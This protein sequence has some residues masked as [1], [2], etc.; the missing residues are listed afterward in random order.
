MSLP[1]WIVTPVR[2]PSSADS[3]DQSPLRALALCFP[4]LTMQELDAVWHQLRTPLFTLGTTPISVAGIVGF[5]LIVFGAWWLAGTIEKSIRRV[6]ASRPTSAAS[7]YAWAR[8][9][10]YG[11]WV[12]ATLV[13][14][15]YIG[16]DIANF[17]LLGGAVGV[18]IGF[19]LQNIF[20]NF[21]SGIILLVEKTLKEGDFVDLQSGT[22]GHVREIGLR[23]TRI[24]TNDEVDVIVPNSE[25]I[26]GRV[27]NW[28]FGSRYR[29]MHVPFGV[30][31][32]SDK[33]QVKAAALRAAQALPTTVSDDTRHSDVWLVAM[34]ESSLDFELVV[35]VGADATTSPARVEAGYIWQLHEELL[36]AGLEI[37]YPQRD[38]HIRSGGLTVRLDSASAA[39][40]P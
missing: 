4:S 22:R 24:T 11:I 12:L 7:I 20:S 36:K 9:T 38:L 10:R 23:Y 29:R 16:I 40:G 26:N 35:W 1:Q 17:A 5:V 31:Y 27:V 19:G 28:T 30:A 34:G 14:L 39:P 25:F 37:P 6:A 21:F 13:G 18:G 15:N 32:G 33:E 8:I 3:P 2:Q